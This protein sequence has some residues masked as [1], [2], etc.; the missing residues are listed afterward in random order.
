MMMINFGRFVRRP[1][2]HCFSVFQQ[3]APN[4]RLVQAQARF[5]A[6]KVSVRTVVFRGV[7]LSCRRV[8]YR[9]YLMVYHLTEG[10]GLMV[11]GGGEV[12]GERLFFYILV[13]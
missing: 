6:K 8:V 9:L 3:G 7:F 12:V 10:K 13:Y 5:K 11:G 2:C 1:C 4:H